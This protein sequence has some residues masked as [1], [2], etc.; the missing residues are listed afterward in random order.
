MS[1][2]LPDFSPL[3]WIAIVAIALAAGVVKG[4]V[5]FAMPMILI[6]GLGSLLP[7]ELALGALIMPT[8]VTNAWQA[9][10]NGIGAAVLS[11]KAHWRYI[12]I[13]AVM[14]GFSAQLVRIL[15]ASALFLLIGTPVSLF[16]ILQLAGV[17]I[18][19][20]AAHR[21]VA[22]VL[23]ALVAGFI[24][25][26]SG[27]WGP[28]TVIY[29]TSLDTPKV[30][31]LRTQGIVYFLGAIAL[32]AAHIQSGIF[33]AETAPLSTL[34]LVPALIGTAI[35][36]QIADRLDQARFRKATLAVLAVVGLNLVRRGLMA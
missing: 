17:R 9:L 24:G 1:F 25:G 16:A 18:G 22:E 33:N 20:R 12:V 29:L 27:V 14:I 5:G 4:S 2:A 7:P 21:R 11:A 6:S 34:L 30:E 3:L 8:L 10:R 19:F 23:I 31:Q 26:I 32:T 15:P 35:G 13:V 36:F 28:P